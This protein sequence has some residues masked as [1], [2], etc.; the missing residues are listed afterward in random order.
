[1]LL[2]F[3]DADIS[4]HYTDEEKLREEYD[5]IKDSIFSVLEDDETAIRA[6]LAKDLEASDPHTN[7]QFLKALD[8]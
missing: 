7:E 3:S 6:A 4:L 1:M 8:E 2:K 5:N